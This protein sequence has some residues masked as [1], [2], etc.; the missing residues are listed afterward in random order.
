MTFYAYNTTL[1]DTEREAK[2]KLNKKYD[3][4]VNFFGLSMLNHCVFL[5]HLYTRILLVERGLLLSFF[6]RGK[7]TKHI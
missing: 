4:R 5:L 7:R 2:K 1:Y 6:I 3:K